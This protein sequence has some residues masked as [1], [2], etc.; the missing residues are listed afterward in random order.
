MKIAVVTDDEKTISVHFGRAQYYM[1]FTVEDGNPSTPARPS[2]PERRVIAQ[3]IRPKANHSQ[4]SGEQG[5]HGEHGNS[6]GMDP[7]SQHRHGMMMDTIADCHVL[8]A[9][10]MGQGAHY[11]LKERGIRPVLTDIQDIQEAVEAFLDGKLIEN[12]ARLH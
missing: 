3:E 1:V 4:F 11:S 12:M 5:H 2:A 8:I 10:G 7:Q 9:R 6:H